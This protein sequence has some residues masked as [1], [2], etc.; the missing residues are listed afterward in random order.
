[1]GVGTAVGAAVGTS[2]GAAVAAAMAT[3][4]AQQARPSTTNV[5]APKCAFGAIECP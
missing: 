4:H 5:G 3:R 2:V 1:M